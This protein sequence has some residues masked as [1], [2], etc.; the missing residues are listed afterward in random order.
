MP[1][2]GFIKFLEAED[3]G[4][5]AADK[6]QHFWP[7]S[8]YRS[9]FADKLIEAADVPG[10]D[11]EA[12]GLPVRIEVVAR[13]H[14]QEVA[15]IGPAEQQGQQRHQRPGAKGPDKKRNDKKAPDEQ[16]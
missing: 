14:G 13:M 2:K 8:Y 5:L 6:I 9:F 16:K 11:T 7:V 3:I 1:G 12:V 4:L 10:Q 15:D